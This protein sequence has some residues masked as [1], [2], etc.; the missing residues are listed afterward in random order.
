MR[1]VGIRQESMEVRLPRDISNLL[2]SRIPEKLQKGLLTDIPG[3]S[4]SDGYAY[5]KVDILFHGI[6]SSSC[7]EVRYGTDSY[8]LSI[9]NK[10]LIILR[11]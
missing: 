6:G 8:S 4:S 5:W 1:F 11:K 10:D 3:I 7:I 2:K 9:P